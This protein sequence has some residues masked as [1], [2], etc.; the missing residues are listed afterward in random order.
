VRAISAGRD[1]TKKN[2]EEKKN[3]KGQQERTRKE[4]ERKGRTRKDKE[5]QGSRYLV[6]KHNRRLL[7][8]LLL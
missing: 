1:W 6:I 4:K 2:K 8:L 3:S 7:E 5:G